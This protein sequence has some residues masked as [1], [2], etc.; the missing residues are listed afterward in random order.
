MTGPSNW[1]L[2]AAIERCSVVAGIQDKEFRAITGFSGALDSRKSTHFLT[3]FEGS[4]VSTA[5]D[6]DGHPLISA[7]ILVLT[8]SLGFYLLHTYFTSN[9]TAKM[10]SG[11][12]DIAIHS[13]K[14]RLVLAH[15]WP[16]F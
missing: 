8:S 3:L 13:F 10:T 5:F 14:V 6:R 16:L 12:P 11:P 7:K 2:I 4:P 15:N 1:E 9:F